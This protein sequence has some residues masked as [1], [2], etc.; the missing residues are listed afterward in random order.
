MSAPIP[1]NYTTEEHIR[2]L[3]AQWDIPFRENYD[4]ETNGFSPTVDRVNQIVAVIFYVAERYEDRLG[5][6]VKAELATL[7]LRM[8]RRLLDMH[9]IPSSMVPVASRN[10]YQKLLI[11][12]EHLLSVR[13]NQEW[14]DEDSEPAPLL[15]A[16]QLLD[17]QKWQVAH[18]TL[19]HGEPIYV[20]GEL[21]RDWPLIAMRQKDTE[22]AKEQHAKMASLPEY[23]LVF[24]L[25]SVRGLTRGTRFHTKFMMDTLFEDRKHGYIKLWVG[26][27]RRSP[28]TITG[29][30]IGELQERALRMFGYPVDYKRNGTTEL[31]LWPGR[32]PSLCE[33]VSVES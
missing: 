33:R 22:C 10:G 6:K 9:H 25:R 4:N 8:F 13:L 27:F 1:Q 26:E 3:F 5:L 20:T 16:D 11:P 28:M 15:Y 23:E 30:M 32:N 31:I 19:G 2:R 7:W 21:A 12:V 24:N 14:E 17:I 18:G 29:D